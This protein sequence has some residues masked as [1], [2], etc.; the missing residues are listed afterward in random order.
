MK[1]IYL[2]FFFAFTICSYGQAAQ[3][4]LF[5]SPITRFTMDEYGN[6]YLYYENYHN[7][8]TITKMDPSGNIIWSKNYYDPYISVGEPPVRTQMAAHDGKLYFAMLELPYGAKIAGLMQLDYNGNLIWHKSHTAYTSTDPNDLSSRL[9]PVKIF[10]TPQYVSVVYNPP[11]V[12]SYYHDGTVHYQTSVNLD[13]NNWTIYDAVLSGSGNIMMVGGRPPF[14]AAASVQLDNGTVNWYHTYGENLMLNNQYSG[15]WAEAIEETGPDTFLIGGI[16][17]YNFQE[18]AFLSTMDAS[19]NLLHNYCFIQDRVNEIF[20][21][22]QLED[23][24]IYMD[25]RFND[26]N[27]VVPN[28]FSAVTNGYIA[29]DPA[30]LNPVKSYHELHDDISCFTPVDIGSVRFTEEQNIMAHYYNHTYYYLHQCNFFMADQIYNTCTDYSPF[31]VKMKDTSYSFTINP[32]YVTGSNINPD[33]T[34]TTLYDNTNIPSID[35]VNITQVVTNESAPIY[36]VPNPA[37]DYI[38]I[39]AEEPITGFDF[40]DMHGRVLMVNASGS[41]NSWRLD[42]NTVDPGVYF[43]IITTS[44]S[45][46]TEKVIVQN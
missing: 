26:T 29:L 8:I 4:W 6:S 19:G 22:R 23:G 42:V 38:I 9:S 36:L 5:E 18:K 16:R 15:C 32:N 37:T 20:G 33:F 43:I 10:I 40:R 13:T 7:S 17:D 31:P 21:I 11:L 1:K 46:V 41:G 25:V 44:H 12:V 27:M 28:E 45:T 35:C 34:N 39:S 2:L 30:T 14:L 3:R 24:K